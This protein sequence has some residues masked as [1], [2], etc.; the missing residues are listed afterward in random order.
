MNTVI[1]HTEGIILTVVFTIAMGSLLW[2]MLNVP[3][4]IPAAAAKARRGI[5]SLKKYLCQ[6]LG[7]LIL[8][9]GWN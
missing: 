6:Q 1:V 5:G 3:P 2:W 4:L 8:N 9:V 7:C